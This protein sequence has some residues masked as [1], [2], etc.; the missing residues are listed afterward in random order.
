MTVMSFNPK[1][2]FLFFY[3]FFLLF[4]VNL[5]ELEYFYVCLTTITRQSLGNLLMS[6]CNVS[7]CY[8]QCTGYQHPWSI[9]VFDTLVPIELQNA[10]YILQSNMMK[11][12]QSSKIKSNLSLIMSIPVVALYLGL[13]RVH[14]KFMCIHTCKMQMMN[15][16]R[17]YVISYFCLVQKLIKLWQLIA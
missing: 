15:K 7:R 10:R 5:V 2:R 6:F 11:K 8:K 1:L 13:Q 12:M 16:K 9:H 4:L 17:I 14:L 3:S